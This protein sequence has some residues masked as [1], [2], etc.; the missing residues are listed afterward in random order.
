MDCRPNKRF[1]VQELNIKIEIDKCDT[2]GSPS[3]DVDDAE[4]KSFLKQRQYC[5][6]NEDNGCMSQNSQN[7]TKAGRGEKGTSGENFELMQLAL[8]STILIDALE[9]IPALKRKC[10]KLGIKGHFGYQKT[11]GEKKYGKLKPC[12]QYYV[13]RIL[14]HNT[15]D[16]LY[17]T[18]WKG[19][20]VEFNSWE[21]ID[22]FHSSSDLVF[23]F[24]LMERSLSEDNKVAY[25]KLILLD[26]LLDEIL[27]AANQDPYLLLKLSR[28]SV[29]Y[30][31]PED[32]TKLKKKLAIR[33]TP[34]KKCLM[35][36]ETK[37]RVNYE[38]FLEKTMK[39]LYIIVA[40]ESIEK[41]QDVSKHRR[42]Y[43]KILKFWEEKINHTI[44]QEEGCAPIE[45][46]NNCDFDSPPNDF[47]YITKCIS[48]PDVNICEEPIWFCNCDNDCFSNTQTCCPSI[49]DSKHIYNRHGCLK[50]LKQTTIFECNSKCKCPSTCSNRVIQNGR[51]VSLSFFI[52]NF[53][54]TDHEVLPV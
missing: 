20:D 52:N 35:D 25:K 12:G 27:S 41:L 23:N 28:K 17:L 5:V 45:L 34:L 13:E 2:N 39:D 42:R 3:I 19:F 33:R 44:S 37:F 40:F 21:P 18:K 46:E 15:V 22:H 32:L 50:S 11:S 47:T 51:K 38:R 29:S 30:Y 6:D 1:K 7:L 36:N 14:D 49:N 16:H 8:N 10:G 48:G 26:C 24:R 53:D 9:S 31:K 43:F 4:D 54:Q